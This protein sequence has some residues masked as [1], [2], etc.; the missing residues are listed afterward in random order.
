MPGPGGEC[1]DPPGWLLLRAV[2]ILLECILVLDRIEFSSLNDF[3]FNFTH[4]A[5]Q[6]ASHIELGCARFAMVV[7]KFLCALIAF[8]IA[9]QWKCENLLGEKQP[10]FTETSIPLRLSLI[11]FFLFFFK[12]LVDISPFCGAT[13]M[14]VFG[15]LVMSPKGLKQKGLMS[16]K[17]GGSP[18]CRL[19]AMK[20]SDSPLV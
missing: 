1:G 2:R 3:Q 14:P 18:L 5:T 4:V 15:L 10:K 12:I 6:P 13:N 20:S 16:S 9:L 7:C 11:F 8:L 17:N 19:C